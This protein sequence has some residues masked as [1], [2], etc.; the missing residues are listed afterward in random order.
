MASFPSPWCALDEHPS[1]KRPFVACLLYGEA[2]K[3][4]RAARQRRVQSVRYTAWLHAG[5]VTRLNTPSALLQEVM[6]APD[7]KAA[8]ATLPDTVP[9]LPEGVAGVN[10][11]VSTSNS[12]R[13]DF[14]QRGLEHVVRASFH[15]YNSREDVTALI[16]ALVHVVHSGG[17]SGRTTA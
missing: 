8:L 15:H 10:V 7:V 4:A 6:P 1:L 3:A 13:L 12:S 11:A 17:S 14:T 5:K 2:H 16:A 9:G